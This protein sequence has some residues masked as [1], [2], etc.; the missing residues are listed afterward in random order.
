MRPS[1]RRRRLRWNAAFGAC[2]GQGKI[3]GINRAAWKE[4]GNRE[5]IISCSL[6]HKFSDRDFDA[7]EKALENLEGKSNRSAW[8]FVRETVPATELIQRL[9]RVSLT[10]LSDAIDDIGTDC[11]ERLVAS[12]TTYARDPKIR[13]AVKIRAKGK[14]EF[15]GEPGFTG[16]DGAPYLEC[17]HVIALANDGADRMTNVIALCA[18]DHREAHFGKRRAELEQKMIRRIRML[19]V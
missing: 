12:V 8:E 3:W 18:N 2:R 19:E 1:R 17:H 9:T 10:T 11:P 14:C 15:C 13:R 7:I 4:W 5:E 16:W 6:Q